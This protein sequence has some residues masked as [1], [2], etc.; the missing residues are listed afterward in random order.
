MGNDYN[1]QVPVPVINQKENE[2]LDIL[3][4]RY[5]K[6][7]EPGIVGK[8]GTK[9]ESLIPQ[10]LKIWGCDIASNIS[11]EKLYTQM[12]KII[13]T[14]FKTIEEQAVKFS[15]SEKQILRQINQCSPNYTITRLDEICLLRSYD[16][17]KLV[18]KYKT[19]DI[20]VAFIEGG[21]TGVCGFWGL[22]FNIALSSFLYYRAVQSIAMYYGYDIKNDSAELYIASEVFASALSP[23]NNDIDN[24]VSTIIVKVMMISEMEVVKQTANKK[25]ADMVA[26]GGI[27]LL[28]TKMR[29][30]AHKA[31]KKAIEK[32]G[33]KG[34]ENILYKDA[35]EQIGR[36]LTQENIVRAAPV[37]SAV[38]G[39]LIDTVQMKTV[40]EFADIF[41]QKRFIM[42]KEKRIFELI[43]LD[44][45][46][47]TEV[48]EDNTDD[49]ATPQ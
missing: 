43:N 23:I 39:A 21:V 5:N 33:K 35:F 48:M 15:I 11:E 13:G 49:T 14:G 3:T 25:W 4:D 36:K 7:I 46:I 1:F 42:E 38:I 41:Y 18:N 17:A 30:L 24:E 20:F 8:L 9:A 47:D 34:L 45:I 6:L 26:R 12:M 32:A 44:T 28:L 27:C 16:I 2:A 37:F 22:P 31:A 19:Q 10:N 40:L 29:A